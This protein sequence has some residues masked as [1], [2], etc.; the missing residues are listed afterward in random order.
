[1]W[2]NFGT[3]IVWIWRGCWLSWIL[4]RLHWYQMCWVHGGA[5]SFVLKRG[6]QILAFWY[7]TTCERLY[8]TFPLHNG[9]KKIHL[10]ESSR[11]D[12]IFEEENCNLVLMNP[13]WPVQPCVVLEEEEGLMAMVC[14][15]HMK[16]SDT[17]Q[18]YCHPPQKP[19]N[20]LVQ[21][22]LTSC[23]RVRLRLEQ[24]VTWT[25]PSTIPPW[26]WHPINIQS[27]EWTLFI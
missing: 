9:I 24:L 4:K 12:Y 5:P 17:K 26:W 6:T 8:S 20:I 3:S 15:H 13:K 7:S 16:Y 18:L 2:T 11:N 23:V 22:D 1:M 25:L 10:V 21:N 14:Q 19:N 27:V